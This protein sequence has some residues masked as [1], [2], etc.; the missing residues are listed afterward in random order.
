MPD[1][2]QSKSLA[3]QPKTKG[4][5]FRAS[6]TS[7]PT[8]P[9]PEPVEKSKPEQRP[10]EKMNPFALLALEIAGLVA[11]FIVFLLI[12]NFFNFVSL[13]SIYPNQ[14][15]FLPHLSQTAQKTNS[16][17]NL[18]NQ[19]VSTTTQTARNQTSKSFN[20]PFASCPVDMAQCQNGQ[21][22]TKPSQNSN[23][24]YGLEYKNLNPNTNIVAVISGN[25]STQNIDQDGQNF[26]QINIT[27]NK[28]NV[29][30]QYLIPAADF[31]Y[32][33]STSSAIT[34]TLLGTFKG[35]SSSASALLLSFHAISINVYVPIDKTSD[36]TGIILKSL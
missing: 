19:N 24:F 16:T 8:A 3:Y 36:G 12:L 9:P 10:K 26:M 27:N 11:V 7:A 34:N 14:L 1:N 4:Y 29:I 20:G 15:G 25:L 22:V 17:S 6:D 5:S 28:M 21:S 33:A 2:S 35:N 32:N 30:A 18:Q 13:S 31:N 23:A